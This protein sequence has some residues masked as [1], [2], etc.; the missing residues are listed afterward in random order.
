MIFKEI[1]STMKS[2]TRQEL[3]DRAGVST[4]T[5]A[6][7]CR[8]HKE[9][10]RRLGLQPRMKMLPPSVVAFLVETLCIDVE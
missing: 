1:L 3:A 9:E 8:P 7:W 10:M 5:L 6:N 4:R 2:M